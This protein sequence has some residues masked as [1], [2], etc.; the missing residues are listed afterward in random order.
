MVSIAHKNAFITLLAS[1]EPI[2]LA[3]LGTI[4][5]GCKFWLEMV[6]F[7]FYKSDSG[8]FGVEVEN[9]FEVQ[10]LFAIEEDSIPVLIGKL[11]AWLQE[12]DD[13]GVLPL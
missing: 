2:V 10:M 12:T 11:K 1:Y 7:A 9:A 3:T 8:L 13:F 6:E 5:D 4:C